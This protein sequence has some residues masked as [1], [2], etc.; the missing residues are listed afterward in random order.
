MVS[1]RPRVAR[2]EREEL[3]KR[4]IAWIEAQSGSKQEVCERLRL[5][6]TQLHTLKNDGAE[7]H[8]LEY[9]LDLWQRCGGTYSLVL[10]HESWPIASTEGHPA[11]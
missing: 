6:T 11:A 8:S 1:E 3:Q 9:L 10:T 5:R 4:I 2:R 7:R